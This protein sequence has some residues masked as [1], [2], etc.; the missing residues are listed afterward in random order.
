MKKSK[1]RELKEVIN[2]TFLKT[3][4]AFAN[5][6]TGQIIFGV[7]DNGKVLGVDNPQ[8]AC[9]DIENKINDTIKPKPEYSFSVNKNTNVITLNVEEGI[10]KPYLYKGK[11][12]R[13]SGSSTV[14]VDQKVRVI[15]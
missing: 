12:Y 5:F 8:Q 3:V 13:R 14:E 4:S 7:T 15:L 2:N 11:A 1:V 9:L 10:Y 6:N